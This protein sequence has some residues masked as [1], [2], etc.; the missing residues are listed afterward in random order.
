ME[1]QPHKSYFTFQIRNK[2]SDTNRYPMDAE[3]V[4]DFFMKG[5]KGFPHNTYNALI[6]YEKAKTKTAYE[7]NSRDFYKRSCFCG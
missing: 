1:L 5:I 7:K 2:D 4:G 6:W 3:D